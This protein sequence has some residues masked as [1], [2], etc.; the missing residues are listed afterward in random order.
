MNFRV[1]TRR[2]PGALINIAGQPLPDFPKPWFPREGTAFEE[3]LVLP[4]AIAR[5]RSAP[6]AKQREQFLAYLQTLGSARRDLRTKAAY[7]LQV[8]RVLKLHTLRD[9]TTEEVNRAAERWS[10]HRG[11][12]SSHRAGRGSEDIFKWVARRWLRFEGKLKCPSARQ[13]FP[14]LLNNFLQ[15]MASERGLAAATIRGRRFRVAAFLRWYAKRH[16]PFYKISLT[17]VDK[18]LDRESSGW[19]PITRAS[20]SACLRAFFRHAES[21]GWCQLVISCAIKSPRIRSDMFEPLGPKWS[22][23]L[24]LLR[25]TS[26]SDS[27]DIRAKAILLLFALY[28]LRSSEVVHLRLADVDWEN[29]TFTIRRAKRGGFQQFPL[30]EEVNSAIRRYIGTTRPKCLCP[31]VFVTITCPY[32]PLI[33]NTISAIVKSR[34][35]KQGIRPRHSGPQSLR[36]AC[37]TRLLSEGASFP[38]IADFLGHR[39]C[40]SVRIYARLNI[41]LLR[42][43]SDLDLVGAL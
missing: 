23:V 6:L 19:C 3:Y 35:Q 29:K 36:H 7:L 13:A 37:A 14:K 5:H 41:N 42:A 8:V 17:D 27:A 9:V 4:S 26:G 34:M 31:N 21:R 18:Y 33:T 30:H 25:A 38:E 20:E 11:R 12:Y 40:E 1:N 28:G 10:R 43:V 15:A 16:R 39:N 2:P 22:E 32:R 24:R